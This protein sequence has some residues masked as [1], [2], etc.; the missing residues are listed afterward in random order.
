MDT[1]SSW[2]VD[3]PSKLGGSG[4]V[5]SFCTKKRHSQTVFLSVTAGPQIYLEPQSQPERNGCF[6]SPS[7]FLMYIKD[8]KQAI[9]EQRFV[10]GWDCGSREFFDV[11]YLSKGA[12][13]QAT[14]SNSSRSS[15][16][17]EI[18]QG[19]WRILLLK[20]LEGSISVLGRMMLYVSQP[21][22]PT[23]LTGL[24]H[25]V[26]PKEEPIKLDRSILAPSA[27][28]YSKRFVPVT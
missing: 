22:L 18:H 20:T 17:S 15:Q 5:C 13:H 23:G 19:C 8:F 9:L 16:A 3:K 1:T 14:A 6:H 24:L 28:G 21:G 27:T 7:H 4:V 25:I 10:S 26:D 11:L 12:S 2:G